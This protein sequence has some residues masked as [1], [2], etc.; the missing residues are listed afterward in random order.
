MVNKEKGDVFSIFFPY[1]KFMEVDQWSIAR[2]SSF[3]HTSILVYVFLSNAVLK[4][5]MKKETFPFS[6]FEIHGARSMVYSAF[7]VFW[8]HKYKDIWFSIQRRFI[9]NNENG[10]FFPFSLFEM[11]VAGCWFKFEI[12][13]ISSSNRQPATRFRFDTNNISSVSCRLP[14]QIS[15]R[16]YKFNESANG[17]SY[18]KQTIQVQRIGNRQ[19]ADSD[20]KQTI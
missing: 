2:L 12:D 17:D 4:R 8:P 13:N 9:A 18:S 6:L 14:I 11:H 10:D 5:I 1:S 15:N 3:G 20:S 16:Q 7:V 19:L